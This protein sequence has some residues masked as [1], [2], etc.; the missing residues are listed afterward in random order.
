MNKSR[1]YTTIEDWG[2][3]CGVVG[4]IILGIWLIILVVFKLQ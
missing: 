2:D 1:F 4:I 3:I